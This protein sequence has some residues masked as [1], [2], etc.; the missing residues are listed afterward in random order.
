MRPAIR[1]LLGGL[2]GLVILAGPGAAP[3]LADDPHWVQYGPDGVVE[4]RAVVAT[5]QC[6]A[7]S[8]DGRRVAMIERA[9]PSADFPSR[10][11]AAVIPAGSK[12][13][14]LAGKELALPAADPRRILVIGD[15]GCRIQGAFIQDCNDPKAWPFPTLADQAARLKPD[16]VIHVGDY[17]YRETACPPGNAGCAGSPFGYGWAPWQADF[18]DP[19]RSLLAAAPWVFVRGNHEDCQRAGEGWSRMLDPGA[20][21]GDGGCI[22]VD[23]PYRIPLGG[24]DLVV[25]DVAV[26]EQ[27][28]EAPDQVIAYRKTFAAAASLAR[29]PTWLLLHRPIWGLVEVVGQGSDAKVIGPNM[30]LAPAATGAIPAAVTLMLSGHIHFFEALNF[31]ADLPPQLIVGNGGDVLDRKVPADP[32]GLVIGAVPV[33]SGIT[34]G[35]FGFLLLERQADD[36]WSGTLYDTA[37]A[38]MRH[39]RLA[40]RSIACGS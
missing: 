18:F 39:C 25:L 14:S 13:A 15:T 33:K 10:V 23:P 9:A 34:Q 17:H 3:G 31:A 12:A 20:M 30:T 1:R 19:A 26:A 38:V 7:I 8:I 22:A 27:S 4:A 35:G 21:P 11:C 5:G 40:D 6:P 29:A 28:K 2:V 32:A 16:L 36:A 37:G 24:L